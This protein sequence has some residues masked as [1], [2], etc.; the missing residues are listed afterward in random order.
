MLQDPIESNWQ[1]DHDSSGEQSFQLILGASERHER[2]KDDKVGAR[3]VQ[4]LQ[5]LIGA[6]HTETRRNGNDRGENVVHE[7]EKRK[8][9]KGLGD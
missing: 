7:E 2:E 3:L 8:E 9:K 5:S 6:P 4:A 1:A